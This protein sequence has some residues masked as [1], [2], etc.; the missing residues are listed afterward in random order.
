MKT[1]RGGIVTHIRNLGS[2]RP[3]GKAYGYPLDEA[4][5]A[6]K[7]VWTLLKTDKSLSLLEVK[8]RY[9]SYSTR[10]LITTLSYMHSQL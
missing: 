5:W 2:R 10:S 6:S 1:W 8:P 7:S 9:P 4:A 3:E